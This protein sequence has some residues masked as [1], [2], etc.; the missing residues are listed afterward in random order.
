M[1]P[2]FQVDGCELASGKICEV[3]FLDGENDQKVSS[4]SDFPNEFFEDMVSSWKGRVKRIHI[5]DVFTEV[6]RA[7]EALYLAVG[8]CN[9]TL[10]FFFF[11]LE[12]KLVQ[13]RPCK[14]IVNS[15]L[16]NFLNMCEN[17]GSL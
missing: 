13:L 8:H 1:F 12:N 5:D 9:L 2:F 11:W 4:F 7:A 10:S 17:Y 15:F 6:E 3:I 16:S 14:L